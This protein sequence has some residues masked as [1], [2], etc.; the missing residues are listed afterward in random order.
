MELNK[1]AKK[2]RDW[3]LILGTE[4]SLFEKL[5]AFS[6]EFSMIEK[7]WSGRKE[8]QGKLDKWFAMHF[9]KVDMDELTLTLEKL[10]KTA[11]LC[12]K[13]LEANEVSRLFKQE[14]EKFKGMGLLLASLRDPALCEDP[15]NKIRELLVR[16]GSA[17]NPNWAQTPPFHA[18][19]D[20]VYTVGWIDRHGIVEWKD[21][22]AEIALRAAKEAELEKMLKNV[23]S[24]W[25]QAQLTVVPYKERTDVSILGNNEDLISKIDDTMLTGAWLGGLRAVWG[26][27]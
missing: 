1:Q 24:F 2:I 23:I 10:Q 21:Q 22:I 8:W 9:S 17:K 13:E 20:P 14:V 12:A 4:I 3:Q 16:Q 18:L 7:L 11:N 15:W 26:A 19:D 5:E 6:R 27:G 25:T